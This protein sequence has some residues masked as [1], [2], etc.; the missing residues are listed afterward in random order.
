[1]VYFDLGVEQRTESMV[2]ATDRACAS[3]ADALAMRP[4]NTERR[5][6][7][8]S[9]STNNKHVAASVRVSEIS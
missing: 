6:V 1:M 2:M 3:V 7:A 9:P 4:A 5:R 8:H